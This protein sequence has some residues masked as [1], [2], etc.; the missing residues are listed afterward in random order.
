MEWTVRVENVVLGWPT[1]REVKDWGGDLTEG[2]FSNQERERI[3]GV[4]KQAIEMFPKARPLALIVNELEFEKLGF[5]RL[6]EA[7]EEEDWEDSYVM[8]TLADWLRSA[9][10][11][12]T[13][14]PDGELGP[15][16]VFKSLIR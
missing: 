1:V 11:K 6:G 12:A 13:S 10:A 16:M 2:P 5:E 3:T 14:G 4:V 9:V 7:W 15:A 8:K